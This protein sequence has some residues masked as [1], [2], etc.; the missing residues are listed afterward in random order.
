MVNWTLTCKRKIAMKSIILIL[1][2]L[3]SNFVIVGCKDGV[4]SVNWRRDVSPIVKRVPVLSCCTNML[5]HGEIITKSSF[6]SPPGPSA[7]RVC[8]FIPSASRVLP[9]LLDI[10]SSTDVLY[11]NDELQSAEKGMLKS[12]FGIDLSMEPGIVNEHL[13]RKLVQPPYW[14]RCIF[15][16]TKDILC[17][18]LFCE[19]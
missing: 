7:Y 3:S 12:E 19:N 17:I 9:S 4:Q 10:E 15:F 5:W 2:I 11:E 16:K 18:I 14:G 13:N 1:I 8:C 6:M